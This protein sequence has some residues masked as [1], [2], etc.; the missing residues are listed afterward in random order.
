VQGFTKVLSVVIA[1][2]TDSEL[3]LNLDNTEAHIH[4]SWSDGL[5][6]ANTNYGISLDTWKQNLEW[7][8]AG[9]VKD[10][11]LLK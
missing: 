10:E 7:E 4:D 9:M 1:H 3:I 2:G 11:R 6:T 5:Q 8:G